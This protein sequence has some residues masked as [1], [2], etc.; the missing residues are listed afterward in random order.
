M[1]RS[2]DH[3]V[4]IQDGGPMLELDNAW[5]THLGC[6]A[7]KGAARRWERQREE[8]GTYISVDPTTL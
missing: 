1:S 2:V 8:D 5:S 3:E 6:N 4:E 7:S